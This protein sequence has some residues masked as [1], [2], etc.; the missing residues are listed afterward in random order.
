MIVQKKDYLSGNYTSQWFANFYLQNLDH[1]IKEELKA[2]YYIQ[3]MDDMLI[4]H[5]NKKELHKIKDKV[6]EYLKNEHLR[7]KENWTLFKVDSRPI[8]FLG[9]RF[10]RGYTTLRRSNFL[11]IKR[12]IKKIVKRGYIRL[13]DAYSVISYHGWL[14]HCDS[15]NY[16]NKYIK[17]YKITLKKCK[18]VIKNGRSKSKL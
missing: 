2:P 15:F 1:Y 14:S 13:T 17:P 3:Y 5:R 8:D 11:R 9:Y 6:E 16:R 10:Y 18:G 12:R 4:F 7:L